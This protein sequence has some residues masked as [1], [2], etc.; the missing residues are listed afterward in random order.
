MTSASRPIQISIFSTPAHLGV[1][2]SA[3]EKACELLGFDAASAGRIVL[4]VD[5]ALT[6]IIRHAYAG[7]NDQRIDIELTP[8]HAGTHTAALQIRL[9][10]YGPAFDPATIPA[11]D[12]SGGRGGGMGVHIINECMDSVEYRKANGDGMELTMVKHVCSQRKQGGP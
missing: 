4:G 7:A 12:F 1:V 6:N 10:D 2:R 11:P 3:V 5:E 8:M 9:R